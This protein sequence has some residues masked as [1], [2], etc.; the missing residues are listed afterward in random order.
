M[1]PQSTA[2]HYRSQ[3][4]LAVATLAAV[5][6]QWSRMSADF[7][8]SWRVLRP[9][10]LTLVAAAQLAAARS[11]A[12]YVP[13]VLEETRQRDDPVGEVSPAAFAGVASDG[14]SLDSLLDGA[15]VQAKE[16][17]SLTAGGSW[18]DMA[19]L[20]QVAD[21]ARGAAGVAIAARPQVT[22]YTRMLNPPSCSRCAV[23]A[24]KWFRWNDGFLRHPRCDC[25][26]IPASEDIADDFRTDP[27]AYF[28]SLPSA[29]S[30]AEKYPDLTVR[31]RT[32]AGIYSQED[33]FTRAG[34]RAIRDGADIGQVVNARRGA[35]GLGVAG[36]QLTKAEAQALR[37]GRDRGALQRRD[38]FGQQLF[39][40]TEGVTVHG[41]AGKRLGKSARTP[42]LMPESIYEVAE[43]RAD[44]IRLLRRF[45]YIL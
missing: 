9:R 11:G 30:L 36:A 29:E 15:V 26:H 35:H 13:D 14:R 3:Q 17:Q 25:R 18:L 4:R 42:R 21:A 20:T 37:G 6:G 31:M 1:L 41:V 22:G 43:D 27:K 38:V 19:V 28:D 34:A 10:V 8:A 24:G 12:A 23:L 16:S 45:G 39:T 5:R 32:E 44:A 2:E 33:I 7:D 40:T